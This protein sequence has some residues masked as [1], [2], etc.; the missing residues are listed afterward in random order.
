MAQNTTHKR[1]NRLKDHLKQ[2]NPTLASCVKSFQKLDKIACKLGLMNNEDTYT[3][4]VSW[5]PVIS[6]LGT[7]SAG[8]STFINQYVGEDLQRT[9]NQAVDDKF[10]IICYGTGTAST[11]LPGLALDSDPRFPFYQISDAIEQVAQGEGRRV[12]SYLQLKTVQE[13]SILGKIVIDSPGF[14]ADEQRTSTLLITDH[15]INLSDLVLVF[16]D[17]RHPEPRAMTDTLRHLV[18]DTVHR[19]DATKFL[20]NSVVKQIY[21]TRNRILDRR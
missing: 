18:G 3:A 7:Y 12:D 8:K 19:S 13:K 5:W 20:Y 6:V 2:E 21:R 4:H 9:G 17:A 10:T 15:I 1:I 14:D 16:F 11:S